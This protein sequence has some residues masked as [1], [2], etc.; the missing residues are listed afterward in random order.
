MGLTSGRASLVIVS[1]FLRSAILSVAKNLIL[2]RT[3][4]VKVKNLQAIS[5]REVVIASFSLLSLRAEGVAIS[6]NYK[7]GYK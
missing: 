5:R 7:G 4:S 3:G 6:T 2:L 1:S